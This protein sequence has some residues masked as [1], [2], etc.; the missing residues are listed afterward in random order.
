VL[1]RQAAP[2]LARHGATVHLRRDDV[3]LAQTEEFAQHAAGDDLTLTAVVDVGRVE[4]DGPALDRR[5]HNRLR[6]RLVERPRPALVP[7]EAHHP[8][9]NAGDAQPRPAE[10]H[11]FHWLDINA[12]GRPV[13]AKLPV[14]ASSY[15][16]PGAPG[17]PRWPARD[18]SPAGADKLG[19]GRRHPRTSASHLL[20]SLAR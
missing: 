3:L 19:V 5:A 9:A 12:A 17:F 15:R 11:V 10:I 1:A 7:A 16:Q 4:E 6:S 2:V 20:R 14:P 18:R 13:M 8:E